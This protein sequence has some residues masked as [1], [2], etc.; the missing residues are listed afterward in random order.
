MWF[1]AM[2]CFSAQIIEEIGEVPAGIGKY[3]PDPAEEISRN[4]RLLLQWLGHAGRYAPKTATAHLASIRAFEALA[5]G[6]PF[7]MLTV[8]DAENWRSTMIATEG[9][10]LSRATLRHR[11]SHLRLFF[12]WLGKQT[13]Y[14][15]LAALEACFDLPRRFQARTIPQPRAWP[16]MDEAVA[17][18]K[19]MPT[20][21]LIDQRARAILAFAFLTG[22]RADA[23]ITVRLRHID[24]EGRKATHDGEEMRTKNGKSFV[25]RWFPRSE[26]FRLA[27][28]GVTQ[29]YSPHSARHTL[30]HLGDQLCRTGEQRKAW[31]LNLGHS[32][33]AITWA[34]YGKI[35]DTRCDEVFE[36]FDEETPATSN[37]AEL[38][39]A[40]HE[41]RLMRGT[42]EFD[43]AEELVERRKPSLR[44]TQG[45]PCTNIQPG[46]LGGGSPSGSLLS[47]DPSDDCRRR[48]C[49][50]RFFW[51]L[52][53]HGKVGLPCVK[54]LCSQ[55]ISARTLCCWPSSRRLSYRWPSTPG[56]PM[57]R[58]IKARSI[59]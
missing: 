38:M 17:M 35:S 12:S 9:G 15:N 52:T 4:D 14:R 44:S 22:F 54:G 53:G 18:L 10:G 39:L 43:L 8:Q 41:H 19:A 47:L 59:T 24:L 29:D 13:G 1:R 34:H 20:D 23:L 3:R 5:G 46:P 55:S 31:S 25:V 40:Y 33:E 7:A 6:K 36:A 58:T 45:R 56:L 30:A 57:S 21:T 28:R 16:E 27:S 11:A 50:G 42:P 48:P 2:P 51:L 32:S 49:I 37:E 26:A